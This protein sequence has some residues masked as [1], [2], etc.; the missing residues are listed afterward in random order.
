M[1]KIVKYRPKWIEV[2]MSSG[3]YKELR[4]WGI[5]KGGLR[6]RAGGVKPHTRPIVKMS[7]EALD[8]FNQWMNEKRGLEEKEI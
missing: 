4:R 3:E 1:L 2:Q 5:L 8:E 6:F 7:K